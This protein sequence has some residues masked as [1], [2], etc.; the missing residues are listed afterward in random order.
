MKN[1]IILHIPHASTKLPKIFKEQKFE[2]NNQEIQDFNYKIC[3]LYTDKLFS[4]L[5][6]KNIKFK[7]S[8][9]FCDVEKYVD[10]NK[11]VMSKYGMGVIY[12]KTHKQKTFFIPSQKYKNYVLNKY[13]FC[14][15]DKLTKLTQKNINKKKTILVDCHSFSKEI[16]IDKKLDNQLPDICI[17]IN[18]YET[19]KN[20][21]EYIKNYFLNLN[22]SVAINYPYCGAIVPNNLVDNKNNLFEIM[23]EINREI[24]YDNNYL[25]YGKKP[26]LNK[27]KF[28]KLK[29]HI[30]LLL[31]SLKTLHL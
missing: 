1:A 13:Y 3:D 2:L 19:D 12:S 10:D 24:I 18:N 9:I 7:Y 30:Y 21:L 4:F 17:G 15:H 20:L 11:E 16:I 6:F 5:K 31:K 27:I 8:R 14:H 26:K 25:K 23:L 29:K 28:K 22:Y